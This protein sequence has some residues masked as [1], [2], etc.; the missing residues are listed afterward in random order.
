MVRRQNGNEYCRGCEQN[1]SCVY[2]RV[3]E[4]DCSLIFGKVLNG[5]RDGL[6]GLTVGASFPIV[7]KEA[8]RH[9][10][11]TVE[12]ENGRVRVGIG[13]LFAIRLLAIG[14]T[15]N[16]ILSKVIEAVEELGRFQGLGPDRVRFKI[17][18]SA[19]KERKWQCGFSSMPLDSV[20]IGQ[21]PFLRIELATPLSIKVTQSSEKPSCGMVEKAIP[22]GDR[23]KRRSYPKSLDCDITLET[24]V[25]ESVRTVRRAINEFGD[26][27]WAADWNPNPLYEIS[28]NVPCIANELRPF[29]QRRNSNRQ[30]MNWE[31]RGFYGSMTFQSVPTNVLPWL[32]CAGML[33]VGDSRNCGAGNWQLKL[34]A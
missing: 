3:F 9:I 10:P 26:E 17:E 18:H 32:A 7:A 29:H 21:V 34:H 15:A 28:R 25:R 2:G 23:F 30:S 6:R 4:P 8:T 1:P 16:S 24:L 22:Q 20:H 27:K 5:A 13:D 14:G 31:F 33:G 19:T 12:P 11:G